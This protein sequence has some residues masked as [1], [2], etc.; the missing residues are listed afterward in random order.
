LYNIKRDKNVSKIIR[1]ETNLKKYGVAHNS[2]TNDFKKKIKETNLKKY[3]CEYYFQSEDFKIK[4]KDTNLKKYGVNHNSQRNNIQDIIYLTKRRNNTIGKSKQ[5]D[6]IYNKLV[7]RYG[8]VIRQYKSEKY[9]FSC[10]F[11]IPSIDLYIEY[12]GFWTHNNEPYVGT[13]AQTDLV[14]LWK[15]KNTPQYNKAINDWTIRDPVKRQ[16][17]K[18]NNLN[19]I[20]FF[21]MN[22]FNEWYNKALPK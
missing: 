19:W 2:Q 10:D 20:E 3:G 18:N 22:E 16:I 17:A 13:D 4:S 7:E 15:S 6:I 1:Q 5:E 14:K 9:P 21:N 11:Y 12:N 8:E